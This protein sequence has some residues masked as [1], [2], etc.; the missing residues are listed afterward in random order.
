MLE[1]LEGRDLLAVLVRPWLVPAGADGYEEGFDR[2]SLVF[3]QFRQQFGLVLEV[4]KVL[5]AE[6]LALAVE[7]VGEPL[8]EQHS[9]DEFLELGGVHLAAQ[10][11]GGL[12]EEGF[13]L[14]EGDLLLGHREFRSII[15]GK[16]AAPHGGQEQV[17]YLDGPPCR[18]NGAVGYPCM[19]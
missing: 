1:V 4:G 13:E 5:L 9:E 7:L 16:P 6:L 15:F 8:Q 19:P 14:G 11:V 12:E 2:R 3:Q 10:D 17:S 18:R